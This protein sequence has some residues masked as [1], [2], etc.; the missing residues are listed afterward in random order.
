MP[1]QVAAICGRS[2]RAVALLERGAAKD[3]RNMHNATPLFL[4]AQA[5]FEDAVRVLLDAGADPSAAAIDGRTP[6]AAAL[7]KQHAAAAELLRARGGR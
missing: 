6:L 2:S 7:E 4:A 1:R 3:A 5:G